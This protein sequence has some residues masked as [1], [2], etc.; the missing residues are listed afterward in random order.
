[1]GLK[2]PVTTAAMT[3]MDR[4]G[5]NSQ[6]SRRIDTRKQP[7]KNHK[8]LL[9]VAVAAIGPPIIFP[10][11]AKGNDYRKKI[12]TQPNFYLGDMRCVISIMKGNMQCQVAGTLSA[13]IASG[14][15]NEQQFPYKNRHITSKYGINDSTAHNCR[16]STKYQNTQLPANVHIFLPF[17]FP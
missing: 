17:H 7:R 14:C 2:I 3:M 10:D 9:V 13:Y 4:N 16:N 11:V 15:K 6:P 1:M 5:H 8:I 12:S